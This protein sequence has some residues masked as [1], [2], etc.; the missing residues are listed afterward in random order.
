MSNSTLPV[1]TTGEQDIA[2][3]DG[4]NLP[5][6]IHSELDDLGLDPYEFRVYARIARRAG[7]SAIASIMKN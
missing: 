4:R 5:I 7:S 2:F 1:S 3:E 6:F